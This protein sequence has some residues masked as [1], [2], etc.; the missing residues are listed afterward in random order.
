MTDF[1]QT[2]MPAEEGMQGMPTSA[3][4]TVRPLRR[5]QQFLRVLIVEDSESDAGLLLRHLDRGGYVIDHAIVDSAEAMS[6]QLQTSTWDIVIAD[7]VLPQFDAPS[8]LKL[9]RQSEQDIPFIVVSGSIGE[10]AAVRM[11]KSGAHDYLLKDNLARLV[12][13]VQ[14]ELREAA[15]RRERER[16]ESEL[17]VYGQVFEASCEAICI[18]DARRHIVSVNPAF[19]DIT[20][21]E[22]HEVIGK[23]A[24]M[25]SS[26]GYDPAFY[27]SI[28]Q[29][30]DECGYWTGEIWA[31]KKSG[32]LFME[33]LSIS[34]IRGIGDRISH[35]VTQGVDITNQKRADERIHYLAHYDSLT[36]LPNRTLLQDRIARAITAAERNNERVSVMFID[37]DRFKNINDSLGHPV[38]DRLLQAV[39][40]RLRGCVRDNDTVAR[41]GGDEFVVVLPET[42]SDGASY[43]A[44]KILTSLS[45]P[46]QVE[47]FQL[48][49]TPSIGVS[50]F[51][52]DGGDIE[53]LIKN[54]DA[55]LYHAKDNGRNN[56]QFFTQEMN[57]AAYERISLENGLRL[58]IE[59]GEFA[60]HYQPQINASTGAVTALEAL[61]RWNHPH[62]GLVPP[63]MFIHVAED[64]GIVIPMGKW[65]LRE[66]CRQISQWQK[67]G[68][69]QVPIAVNISAVQLRDKG[70]ASYVQEVLAETGLPSN[71]LQLELTESILMQ[72]ESRSSPGIKELSALGVHL[73]LDDF[74]TGYSSLTYLRRFPISKLK[75]DRSFIRNCAESSSDG[76]IVRAI[77]NLAHSLG[78]RVIAEGVETEAQYR[79]V[80]DE[81]VDDIQGFYFSV[82]MGPEE[83]MG[84]LMLDCVTPEHILDAT[85]PDR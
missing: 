55:A 48:I 39:A 40:D 58:G 56:Y 9:L 80:I 38:G 44:T 81:G 60:L 30:V 50:I 41:L 25:L 64:S 70:F 46:Y 14:R 37:L 83:L 5:T 76:A 68:F 73:A 51:P 24:Q 53:T 61:V 13:A 75:I 35:Y 18:T 2:A 69:P 59:R 77:I 1:R 63:S 62:W 28:W 4:D 43:V 29:T 15:V 85:K 52:E 20:G 21:Y 26:G 10:D 3:E 33:W 23:T 22:R 74:G 31:R 49:I 17:R 66:A 12:P 57:I 27:Q 7:Y 84:F 16:V 72:D 34:A 82:P 79:F 65:M 78:L 6:H 47:S 36:K 42:G 32:D 8:A 71:L 67:S 19:T 54:A 11:M 45:G